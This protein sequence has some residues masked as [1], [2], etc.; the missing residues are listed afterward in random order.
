MDARKRELVAADFQF[1]LSTRLVTGWRTRS[2]M[3]SPTVKRSSSTPAL[4]PID[5]PYILIGF[6]QVR[7]PRSMPD[8][9]SRILDPTKTPAR[10]RGLWVSFDARFRD[11]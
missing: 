4:S 10:A 3:V 8:R 1:H 7:A 9:P 11:F 2:I 6:H 5:R